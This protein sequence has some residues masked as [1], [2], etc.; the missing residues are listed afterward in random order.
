MYF[1]RLIYYMLGMAMWYEFKMCSTKVKDWERCS[2][3]IIR[4][5]TEFKYI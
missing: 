1:K 2:W 4:N 3:R 5:F